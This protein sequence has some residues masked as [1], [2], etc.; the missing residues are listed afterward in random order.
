MHFRIKKCGA[1]GGGQKSRFN[2]YW[3]L[4]V[5]FGGR[6]LAI[7]GCVWHIL[8]GVPYLRWLWDGNLSGLCVPGLMYHFSGEFH[9]WCILRL[10]GCLAYKRLN[11]EITSMCGITAGKLRRSICHE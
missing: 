8:T 4:V 11:V 2:V 7:K 9:D 5:P 1:C 6:N 3:F 10:K